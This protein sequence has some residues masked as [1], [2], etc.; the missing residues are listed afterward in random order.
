MTDKITLVCDI[1]CYVNYFLVMFRRVDTGFTRKFEMFDGQLLDRDAVH[2][3]LHTYRIVTFN[4]MK[5]DIPMLA[6]A[7][8]GRNCAALKEASD[9][10]IV[11]NL[12]PWQFEQLYGIKALPHV[13]HIDISEVAPGV[14]V[15]LK[16]YAGRMHLPR[17]Q[18]L[19]IEPSA[20]IT[21]A[22]RLELADYCGN[23]DLPATAALWF[24]LTNG[25]D[26]VIGIRE[27]IGN[28]VGL[29][30]RSKS[31]AQVAEAVIKATVEKIKGI[32]IFKPAIP[33]GTSYRYAAPGYLKFSSQPLAELLRDA[34]S[35][36]F[37]VG[38]NG[39]VIEPPTI[40]DRQITINGSTYAVGIGGL[41]SCEK[42]A[43]HLSDDDCVL[44][45]RDV[46]SFYPY[47]IKTCGLAPSNM[48]DIFLK[49]YANWIDR[50]IAA[51]RSGDKT[52]AQTLKIFLNGLYGKLGSPY[53]I[54][55]APDLMIQVTL[56]GQL[57]LLMLIERIELAGIHVV[58]ANTDGIVIKCPRNRENDL[59]GIVQQ[60]EHETG[61]ETEETRY[62][63][64]FSRDI[65][66]YIALKEKGGSKTKGVFSTPGL[67]KNV[68]HEICSEAAAAFLE[69][70]TPVAH[71]VMSCTDIRK[72]LIMRKVTGGAIQITHSH[73]DDTLTP[74]QKR[75]LLLANGWYQTVTGRLAE[76]RFDLIPDG[77]GY[78]AETAY[79]MH[80]G[81]DRYHYLGK[82]IRWHYGRGVDTAL[83]GK[84]QNKTGGRNKVP[85]SDGAVPMMNLVDGIPANLDHAAYI[86]VA[87]GILRDVGVTPEIHARLAAQF[88]NSDLFHV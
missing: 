40:K 34:V 76:A 42:S 43:G 45:D 11:G 13:D 27:R 3:I 29:E 18:D 62:K 59:L 60:W 23:S 28:E 83:Y 69:H 15:S 21:P 86:R 30:L 72:F 7:L 52:T 47:L 85:S 84:K 25:S 67:Q 58:S 24:K 14:M 66:N 87:E 61:M 80:C 19:P 53:S 46:A 88:P 31:D 75:D 26:D 77:C 17:L 32:R 68:E 65:N 10:I 70:G 74:G 9:K 50:R 73:Y 38:E 56:T 2:K 82:V 49:V 36:H 37:I 1:E 33:S 8:H 5:Y 55:Y 63:A 79:R 78:D 20:V 6:L 41:H 57:V 48:G 81:D 71:T 44:L 22:Q 35:A 12:Q 39:K 51:K 64:L 54:V 4:G 16:Q